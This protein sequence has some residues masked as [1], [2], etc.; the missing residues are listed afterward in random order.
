MPELK[1]PRLLAWVVPLFSPRSAPSL[2]ILTHSL[3]LLPVLP[4]ATAP[5]P[6]EDLLI[7]TVCREAFIGYKQS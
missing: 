7:R 6:A 5:S 3:A 4:E 2:L 1:A